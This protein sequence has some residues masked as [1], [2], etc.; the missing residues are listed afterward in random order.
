MTEQSVPVPLPKRMRRVVVLT[1]VVST[2]VGF[3]AWG[4]LARLFDTAPIETND[5]MWEL[6]VFKELPIEP[7][8][9]RE[10]TE[11]AMRAQVQSYESMRPS[12][13]V[14]LL[15]LS[16]LSSMVFVS[17]L[18]FLRPAGVPRESTRRLLGGGAIACAL[19]RTLDGA[20]MAA[21]FRRS[22]AAADR[23]YASVSSQIP[24]GYPDGLYSAGGVALVAFSTLLFVGAYLVLGSYFRSERTREAV[25]TLD[26]QLTT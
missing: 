7:H 14:I 5:A 4:D 19:L 9:M 15:V 25:A 16:M 22:G 2:M 21:V 3:G 13:T 11:A 8:V 10:A 24:G 18:R 23:I 20:Q 12:R 17:A 6:P 1:M 26:S